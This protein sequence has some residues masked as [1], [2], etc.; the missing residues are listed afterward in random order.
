MVQT[1]RV[2]NCLLLKMNILFCK[3]ERVSG[4]KTICDT[5]LRSSTLEL[6]FVACILLINLFI[7][8]HIMYFK[9]KFHSL[10]HSTCI[11]EKFLLLLYSC[12]FDVA[13]EF[14]LLIFL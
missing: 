7:M 2:E 10:S 5:N 11:S 4:P 6:V 3:R 8:C 13:F 9:S 14:T 12:K 1:C